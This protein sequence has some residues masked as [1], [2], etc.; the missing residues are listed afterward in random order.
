MYGSPFGETFSGDFVKTFYT[1]GLGFRQK[2]FYVDLAITISMSNENYYMYNPNY[3][4]RST[5][6]NSGTTIGITVGSKF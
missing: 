4:D 3:V 1:G 6:K 5:L 2:K